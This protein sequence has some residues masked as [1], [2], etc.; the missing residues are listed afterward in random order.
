M[1]HRIKVCTHA[2]DPRVEWHSGPAPCPV[3]RSVQ[4]A[5]AFS[6]LAMDGVD[7]AGIATVLWQ[8]SYTS[9]KMAVATPRPSL[10]GTH[11]SMTKGGAHDVGA[12]N[13][14]GFAFATRVEDG[15]GLGWQI[16]G[17]LMAVSSAQCCQKE[18][19]ED[20]TKSDD[21]AMLASRLSLSAKGLYG[22]RGTSLRSIDAPAA[23]LPSWSDA[24]LPHPF[25]RSHGR[26]QGRRLRATRAQDPVVQLNVQRNDGLGP[27]GL[28]ARL[29]R[30]TLCIH[31]RS[32]WRLALTCRNVH[33]RTVG[34]VESLLL[35][36][37]IVGGIGGEGDGRVSHMTQKVLSLPATSFRGK[38]SSTEL[39]EMATRRSAAAVQLVKLRFCEF[40][41]DQSSRLRCTPKHLRF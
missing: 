39:L 12:I 18:A 15:H 4:Q 34:H 40:Q 21:I 13:A 22:L 2:T 32:R 23:F 19:A 27:E 33:R 8:R 11:V 25:Q 5:Y 35:H 36:R 28:Y 14:K 7:C 20:A 26:L 41:N 31:R 6:V 30:P 9:T 16:T 29:I 10:K 17:G 3:L 1:S 38:N 37:L 24:S